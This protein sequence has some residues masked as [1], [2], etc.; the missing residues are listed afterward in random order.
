MADTLSQQNFSPQ[1]NVLTYFLAAELTFS[2]RAKG[3]FT[4]AA[5]E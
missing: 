4:Y 3:D 2:E 5:T 1:Q